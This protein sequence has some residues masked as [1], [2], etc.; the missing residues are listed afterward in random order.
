MLI[1]ILLLVILATVLFGEFFGVNLV[2]GAFIAGLALSR[3]VKPRGGGIS[4]IGR[5]ETIGYGLLVP[6]LFVSIGMKTDF[7][8]FGAS[9]NLTIILLTVVGLIGSKLLSGWLSLKLTGFDSRHGLC[10]GLM[11]VPQLSATLAAAAIGKD[12]GMLDDNFFN[13][14]II[15]SIVTTLPIPTLVRWIIEHGRMHFENVDEEAY[16]VTE[17]DDEELL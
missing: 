4:L 5:F 6:F 3:L 14:I 8:A 13:A 2:V 11:T 16:L 7:S 10:A 12:L 1:P 9:G 15:L 17:H